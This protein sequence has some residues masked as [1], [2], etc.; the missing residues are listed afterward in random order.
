MFQVSSQEEINKFL[1]RLTS[2]I[3]YYIIPSLGLIG[4]VLNLFCLFILLNSKFKQRNNFKYVIVKILIE[5]VGCL[6][7]I[8][9]QNYLLFYVFSP[10]F[11]MGISDENTFFFQIYRKIA[12]KYLPISLY[13]WSGVNELMLTYDRYLILKNENIWFNKEGRFKYILVVT[14]LT[15]LVINLPTLAAYEIMQSQSQTDL[16]NLVLTDFGKSQFYS[17]YMLML[18]G[19]SNIVIIFTLVPLMVMVAIEYKRFIKR[20]LE[21]A[22]QLSRLQILNTKREYIKFNKM[23]LWLIFLF[24]LV[25]ITDLITALTNR[26]VILNK[27]SNVYY[28]VYLENFLYVSG[29]LVNC[30]NFFVLLYFNRVFRKSFKNIFKINKK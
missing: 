5:L 2:L 9:F 27:L 25:R 20:K 4:F 21:K 23:T 18:L 30:S 15:C 26:I 13:M 12:F 11:I 19:F 1:I 16:Y 17:F 10:H 22:S 6:I 8:G 29:C 28:M 3:G 24:L 14:V 7:C